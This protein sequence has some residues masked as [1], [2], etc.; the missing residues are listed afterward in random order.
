MT[1]LEKHTRTL[2][3]FSQKVYQYAITEDGSRR[4]LG[5]GTIST[6]CYRSAEKR[7][8][9]AALQAN[10]SLLIVGEAGSGKTSHF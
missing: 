5:E 10:S 4:S 2:K 1:R 3:D 9:V 8:I 7:R 6:I